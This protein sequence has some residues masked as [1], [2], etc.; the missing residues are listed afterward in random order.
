MIFQGR[1]S[2]QVTHPVRDPEG[3][4]ERFVAH[5]GREGQ[6]RALRD[7]PRRPLGRP[8]S[9]LWKECPHARDP[10]PHGIPSARTVPARTRRVKQ[11]VNRFE[12]GTKNTKH[13]QRKG[14]REGAEVLVGK[15]FRRNDRASDVAGRAVETSHPQGMKFGGSLGNEHATQ[16]AL[17]RAVTVQ[18]EGASGGRTG[19]P[20]AG[21]DG[22]SRHVHARH[23][24]HPRLDGNGTSYDKAR[25]QTLFFQGAVG[26]RQRGAR[27]TASATYFEGR[28]TV[29]APPFAA[30]LPPQG[31]RARVFA[32]RAIKRLPERPPST[33]TREKESQALIRRAW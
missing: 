17:S 23:R 21:R 29:V 28:Y 26:A 31:R 30:H 12:R 18:K 7:L 27:I 32:V 16:R 13:G 19:L 22:G 33:R 2:S 10:S 5:R 15:D 4:G 9:N 11:G 25:A 8:R 3:D 14:D 6:G 20:A 24:R 1:T